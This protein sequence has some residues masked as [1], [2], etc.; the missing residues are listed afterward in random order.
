MGSLI[1]ITDNFDS[2]PVSDGNYANLYG[3][4]ITELKAIDRMN[5]DSLSMVSHELRTPLT[6]I[7]SSAE[8]LLAYNDMEKTDQTES[9]SMIDTEC[10]CL[11]RLIN[12]VLDLSRIES[13]NESWDLSEVSMAELIESSTN[14][15]RALMVQKNLQLVCTTDDVLPSVW[16]D[17]D[18]LL[19]VTANLLSNAI[20]FTPDNGK[21]GVKTRS[22]EGGVGAPGFPAIW[23]SVSD[24]GIGESE[25]DVHGV[26]AKFKQVTD[27]ISSTPKGTG[28]G[29]PIL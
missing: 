27:T 6:R 3:R 4:D 28:L 19:P 20:K 9:I 26:F 12:D 1:D 24:T 29:L 15:V 11:T 14:S 2:A 16:G 7:K 18:R 5:D 13:G 22:V 8:I 17:R 23:V 25:D 21:I 10:A